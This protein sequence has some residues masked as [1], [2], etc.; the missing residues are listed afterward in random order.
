M[1][2]QNTL[3]R[4][5]QQQSQITEYESNGEKLK[6]SPQIIKRYLVSG[7][8]NAVTDQ[9]VMMFLSLCRFQHLNPFLKEAY[10]IKYGSQPAT[11]VVGKETFIKRAHRNPNYAGRS[12]GI[13]VLDPETGTVTEREGTFKLPHE[14]IVGGWAKVYVTGHEQPEYA[15]VS[16]AEYAGRKKDGTLNNQWATKPGTM[17]RKVAL[18]QALREAFPE[19][20]AGMYSPEEIPAATEIVLNDTVAEI[21]QPALEPEAPQQIP[22]QTPPPQ[23]FAQQ[24][25]EQAFFG[26]Q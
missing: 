20:Y 16:F 24:S 14:E 25:L 19:D 3:Q 18:V 22:Q 12:A 8:A 6:L 11:I 23:E 13:I 15:S 17:I 10:L 21:P 4:A 9:E 1:A 2:V 7:D 5:S 26:G